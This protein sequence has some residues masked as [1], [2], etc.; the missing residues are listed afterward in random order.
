MNIYDLPDRSY[1]GV[2]FLANNRLLITVDKHELLEKGNYSEGIGFTDEFY[3]LDIATGKISEQ[4]QF[5]PGLLL[6][7]HN[8]ISIQYNSDLQYVSYVASSINSGNEI[9]VVNLSNNEVF[10]LNGSSDTNLHMA[11]D[12]APGWIPGTDKI[13]AIFWM[14]SDRKKA[15]YYS[16]SLD[17]VMNNITEFSKSEISSPGQGFM[18]FPKW[19]SDGKFLVYYK[20]SENDAEYFP[21]IWDDINQIESR[22][23]F[24]EDDYSPTYSFT[25]TYS[26]IYLL[27][28]ITVA[29]YEGGEAENTIFSYDMKTY[30]VDAEHE[31]LYEIPKELILKMVSKTQ[32]VDDIIIIGLVNL[33]T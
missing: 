26:P 19:S 28:T 12:M 15:N 14:N 8:Q 11:P 16:L 10:K 30:L 5:L 21:Y 32:N 9:R 2:Q 24:P 33:N 18:V 7:S 22:L 27:A 17:G 25:W 20:K 4:T 3:L 23:C 13:S 29:H 6:L 1:D 31:I